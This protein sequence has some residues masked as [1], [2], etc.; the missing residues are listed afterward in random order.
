VKW[1]WFNRLRLWLLLFGIVGLMLRNCDTQ[2]SKPQ[3]DYRSG[4]IP[5]TLDTLVDGD[6]AWFRDDVGERIK[7]RFIGIDAPDSND[8]GYALSSGRAAAMLG[9]AERI[10]LEQEPSHPTDRHGRM[11]AWVWLKMQDGRELLLQEELLSSGAAELFRDETGSLYFD[12]LRGAAD[13]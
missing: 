3:V 10:E 11:L 6:T 2:Q 8:P 4:R 9:Q 1:G 5:V 7:V 13:R 12:R